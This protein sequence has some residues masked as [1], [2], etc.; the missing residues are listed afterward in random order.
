M[1]FKDTELRAIGSPPRAFEIAMEMLQN[2]GAKKVLDCPAGEGPFSSML[3]KDG[4]EVVAA[5]VCPDQFGL[6]E[7]HCDYV[8]LNDRLPY[9]DNSFDAVACL[10]GLQR[11]WA[12]GRAMKEFARVLRPGGTIV[13]SFPNNSDI[14]R[15][16]MFLLT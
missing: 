1:Y 3:L 9:A 5:D 4:C 13:V 12:R 16:L 7:M 11:V 2:A 15:R 8:D 6:Q 10:N 14:R